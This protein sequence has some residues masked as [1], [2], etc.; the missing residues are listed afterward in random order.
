MALPAKDTLRKFILEEVARRSAGKPSI[1]KLTVGLEHEFFLTRES[2]E[3]ADHELSQQFLKRLAAQPGWYIREHSSTPKHG[4]MIWRCSEDSTNGKYTAVKY[5]HH[6][7]LMEIAFSYES[8]LILMEQVVIEKF[9]VL[10]KAAAESGSRILNAPQLPVEADSPAVTSSLATFEKL[11]HYRGLLFDQRQ[12]PRHPKHINY[13]A[14]IAASQTHVGG[15]S[16][17]EHPEIVEKLYRIEPMILAAAIAA[18]PKDERDRV[19][20]T[21]WAGYQ[22]V[23]KGFPLVGFPNIVAWDLDTW[24]AALLSSP[25]AG[26]PS[27][28]WSGKSIDAYAQVPYSDWSKAFPLIRDLQ[29]VRP[30][31]FGT[32]EFRADPGQPSVERLMGLM[33]LRLGLVGAVIEGESVE[34]NFKDSK[35]LWWS[36][37]TGAKPAAAFADTRWLKAASRVLSLRGYGEEVY[38][39]VF[40]EI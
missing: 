30:R 39:N 36:V 9:R 34:T 24:V 4:E 40:G 18:F 17:W 23:F 28:A 7:H 26:G 2:G 12:E 13:A 21:R 8:N 14:I 20:Q 25:L 6:P 35:D 29:I 19:L 16:W 5:D 11:R 22:S 10:E 3:P 1:S 15:T 37:V 32:L 38:L 31:L 33:A 27:D